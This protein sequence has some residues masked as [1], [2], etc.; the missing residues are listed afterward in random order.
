MTPNE[1][2]KETQR[3]QP[4]FE[5]DLQIE[6]RSARNQMI[7]HAM[8]GLCSESGEIADAIKKH[9]IYNQPLDI[10]NLEEE[11]GD[12]M[13]YVALGCTAVGVDMES[14]IQGNINKL[15]LRYPEKFTES[16]AKKRL[17]KKCKI[18]G[19]TEHPDSE[20]KELAKYYNQYP[21]GEDA[22]I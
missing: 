19:R 8:L 4:S 10:L 12:I 17:D 1:Y 21:D 9:V 16:L 2:Q 15:K 6:K 7:I 20:C 5:Q 3:T 14:I 11:L 13:W 18:C 22:P